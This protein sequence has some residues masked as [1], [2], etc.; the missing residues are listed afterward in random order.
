MHCI[1]FDLNWRYAEHFQFWPSYLFSS[2][3]VRF[4]YS[5]WALFFSVVHDR[6]AVHQSRASDPEVPLHKRV[7]ALNDRSARSSKVR[8]A[9][10]L[11]NRMSP[12]QVT[13]VV[14]QASAF[15][16]TS[17]S[18]DAQKMQELKLYSIV[19]R[20]INRNG[21][22]A[23]WN[24]STSR[25]CFPPQTSSFLLHSLPNESIALCCRVSFLSHNSIWLYGCSGLSRET[26]EG[27]FLHFSS[28]EAKKTFLIFIFLG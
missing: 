26:N 16:S 20:S 27:T 15:S 12:A 2:W 7:T 5:H 25:A 8:R 24:I 11:T 13:S 3:L 4:Y 22:L 14:T 1:L 17:G 28:A 19:I 21:T 23:R 9:F 10:N 6:P 18:R